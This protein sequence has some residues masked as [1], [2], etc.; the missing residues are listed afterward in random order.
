M[1]RKRA[2]G[3]PPQGA[4]RKAS[5]F[6]TR[7]SED[8][9]RQ[10]DHAAQ[11][12]GHSVSI[13]AERRLRASFSKDLR[14]ARGEFLDTLAFMQWRIAER[15]P[16]GDLQTDRYRFE[17]FKAAITALLE[18]LTPAGPVTPPPFSDMPAIFAEVMRDPHVVGLFHEGEAWRELETTPVRPDLPESYALD[19]ARRGFDK[20]L[21]RQRA[22]KLA[23]ALMEKEDKDE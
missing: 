6:S 22:L 20:A 17:A 13:E 23:R 19:Q 9:R 2:P 11:S 16:G 21:I 10:L 4:V 14:K 12:K 18:R 7:L 3:R 15:L 1:K 5:W 8:T